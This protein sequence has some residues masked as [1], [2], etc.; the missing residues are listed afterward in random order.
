MDWKQKGKV[1]WKFEDHFNA[2][3]IVGSKSLGVRDPEMLRKVCMSRFDPD[4]TTKIQ[5]GDI[6]IAGKN[7]GYGN[8]HAEAVLSLK[9]VGVSVLIA[10]SFY[11]TWYRIA[12]FHA[13]PVISCL[14]ILSFAN[15][16]D[17]LD[18]DIKEGKIKKIPTNKLI[19]AEPFPEFLVPIMEAGGLVAHLKKYRH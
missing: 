6:M 1:I 5:R 4:F 9:A 18:I 12:I 19:E 7:F 3:L 15:I 10:Q 17:E 11:P 14:D 16:G 2:D 8:P 13:F